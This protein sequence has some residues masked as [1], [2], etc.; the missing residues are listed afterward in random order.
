VNRRG[1]T[2][3]EMLVVVSIVSLMAGLSLPSVFAGLDTLRLNE[4]SDSVA[5][6][7]NVAVHRA[8]RRQNPVQL[9]VEPANNRMWVRALPEGRERRLEMP[10]GVRILGVTPRLPDDQGQPRYFLVLPG[11]TPPRIAIDLINER[12]GR[13]TVRLDPITG[14]PVV[15]RP[16]A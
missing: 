1:V 14:V 8:E 9:M 4:A 12:G 16:A 6:L 15:E 3:L 10:A 13:R 5:A 7:L 11:A 2:L